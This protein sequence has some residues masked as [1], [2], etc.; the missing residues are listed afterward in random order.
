MLNSTS[1]LYKSKEEERLSEDF[2][3]V[4]DAT[5]EQDV[6]KSDLPVLVDF[7]AV[8]CAPCNMVIPTLEYLARTFKD[9]LKIVKL[10]VDENMATASKFGV[11][12]IPTLL[13]FKN[14][15]IEETIVGAQPQNKIVDIIVKHL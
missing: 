8:W 12:S 5:F 4:T 11:M 7:W 3:N 15:G 1:M 13:L 2:L 9:K 10:N 14:G 6:L